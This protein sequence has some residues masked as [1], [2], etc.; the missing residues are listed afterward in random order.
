MKCEICHQDL[1]QFPALYDGEECP[2]Q[3]EIEL[4]KLGLETKWS[5]NRETL[6]VIK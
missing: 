5:K 6:R 3:Q 2:T 4:N 1:E